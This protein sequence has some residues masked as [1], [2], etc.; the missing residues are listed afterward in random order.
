MKGCREG[1]GTLPFRW[2]YWGDEIN[3]YEHAQGKREP[4]EGEID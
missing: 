3:V 1:S 2:I 4:A